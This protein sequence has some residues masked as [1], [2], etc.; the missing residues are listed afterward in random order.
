MIGPM[1]EFLGTL[2]PVQA[3]IA[4]YAV[5]AVMAL[6]GRFVLRR[7]VKANRIAPRNHIAST[8][9]IRTLQGLVASTVTFAAFVVATLVA[10]SILID[11]QTILWIFGLFSAAF[12]LGA[13]TVV[14]D[15][16]HGI[17]F[18]FRNTFDVGEKVEFVVPGTMVEGVIEEVSLRTTTVR[19]ASG[20]LWTVPNGEI[21]VVRNFARGTFSNASV[22][23]HIE[24]ADLPTALTVLEALAPQAVET[25]PS[26]LAPWEVINTGSEMGRRTDLTLIAR[27]EFGTAATLRPKLLNFVQGR[28]QQAGVR[29][30]D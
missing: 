30:V 10:L 23:V 14:R 26:L 5:A 4:A 18:M 19:A 16:A 7:L 9:R 6:V 22:T 27:A 8:Q 15:I 3:S 12:G 28:L 25:F 1:N 21:R 13:Q 29:L 24:T 20:E 11:T 2:S 17:T